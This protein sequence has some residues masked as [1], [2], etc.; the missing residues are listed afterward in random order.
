MKHAKIAALLALASIDLKS[1][2]F[3]NEKFVELKESQL[4]KIEAALAAAQTAA[5]NTALEQLMAELKANNEKLSA[6][7][8]ALTAEKEALTAEKEALTA[9]VNTLTAETESLKTELNNRPAHSLPAN[10]GKESADNNGLIDGY[11]DPND[12]HNKFLNEI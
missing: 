11:L 7:K 1:P 10:D 5:D 2:L 6:E 3:G 8:T 12:A 4:D 9:Q